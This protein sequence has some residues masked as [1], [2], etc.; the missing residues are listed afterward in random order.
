MTNILIDEYSDADKQ[1]VIHLIL[2][3]QQKE[4]EI[5]IDLEAQPDLINISPFYQTNNGNFWVAKIDGV[6]AGTIALL[7]IGNHCVALR[8]MFVKAE[9][10][11]SKFGIGQ[12]LL[13][14]V[15]GWAVEKNIQTIV[16]GTTSKFLAAQRFYEKN[17]FVEIEKTLL[18]KEFPVMP[19]DVKFYRCKVD[20]LKNSK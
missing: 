5:P 6:V 10:R 1:A 12:S 17:G 13:N 3:I 2:F 15:F 16:L 4:F 7:D 19:V 20:E 8:K 18:P 14:T 11:G 9:Y